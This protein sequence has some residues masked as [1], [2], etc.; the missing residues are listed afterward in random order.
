M[1]IEVRSRD[2]AMA[3]D[4]CA[5]AA[6]KMEVVLSR[7]Q[8]RIASI[9][10]GLSDENGP[11]GGVDKTCRVRVQGRDAWSVIVSAEDADPYALIERA[12]DRVGQAVGRVIARDRRHD[13]K[14]S[15]RRRLP[16]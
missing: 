2:V 3:E 11:R 6:F 8:D 13:K 10:V 4:I 5:Q 12:G 14:S 9:K 7:F 15:L 16:D 1:N